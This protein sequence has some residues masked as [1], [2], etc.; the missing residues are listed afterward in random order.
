[1]PPSIGLVVG[2]VVHN[3]RCALDHLVCELRTP[4]NKA[5][6]C[7][8][9]FPIYQSPTKFLKNDRVERRWLA[10]LEAAAA[11]AI[12]DLQPFNR[13]SNDPSKDP[14]S[15]LSELD[16]IDKHRTILVAYPGLSYAQVR[17]S[18][19][20]EQTVRPTETSQREVRGQQV[21][22]A[23]IPTSASDVGT[24]VQRFPVPRLVFRETGCC[25]G[26]FVWETL[27]ALI[28]DVNSIVDDFAAKGF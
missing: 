9:Q 13:R 8:T 21:V 11:Q 16:N 19:R 6:P 14:L 22:E 17:R 5:Q 2:D 3:L 20:T 1:M 28:D 23:V 27:R 26:E 24:P 10:P 18:E 4:A 15:I 12:R 25:D 7:K